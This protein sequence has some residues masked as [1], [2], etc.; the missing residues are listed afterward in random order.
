LKAKLICYKHKDREAVAILNKEC[1]ICDEC[2][3]DAMAYIL[4][5]GEMVGISARGEPQYLLIPQRE[6]KIERS[7]DNG[8]Y[9]H[10]N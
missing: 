7:L 3:T 5:S 4:N 8:E 9:R 10:Y 6:N 2:V 1:P